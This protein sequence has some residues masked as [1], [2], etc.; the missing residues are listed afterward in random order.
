MITKIPFHLTSKALTRAIKEEYDRNIYNTTGQLF[1]AVKD[2]FVRS[3]M[4]YSIKVAFVVSPCTIDLFFQSAF[5]GILKDFH[6]W[7]RWST[8]KVFLVKTLN[9]TYSPLNDNQLYKKANEFSFLKSLKLWYVCLYLSNLSCYK[10]MIFGLSF[11][12][13]FNYYR[14]T[15]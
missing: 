4:H 10:N 7:C 8:W 11:Q 2:V 12:L 5:E 3:T 1:S 14:L 15:F 6:S 9:N 13:I